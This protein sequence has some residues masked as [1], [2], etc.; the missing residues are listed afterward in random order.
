MIGLVG[1]LVSSLGFGTANIVI[2]K[3]LSKLTI[4]Q[5][6]MMSTLSSAVFLIP[7]VLI[8]KASDDLTQNAILTGILLAIME[9]SLYLVLYKAF[10]IANVSVATSMISTYPIFSAIVAILFL[11]EK[12][13]LIKIGLIVLIVVGAILTS[14]KWG[15]VF[16]D[17]FDRNDL[18]RGL[19]WILLTIIIHAIYFPFLGQFTSSGSWEIRLL[20]IKMFASILI[21]SL[22]FL[23]Q[24]KK[25]TPPKNKI[26]FTSLLGLLE[27]IGW[28]GF[29]WTNSVNTGKTAI[30]IALQSSAALVTAVLAYIFLKER[31]S[32]L[33]YFGILLIIV[34]VTGLSL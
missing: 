20:I 2:K 31:L 14:I 18:V 28:I 15:N 10:E 22:F 17:G 24:K 9:I 7:V 25:I 11:S 27:V 23:I 26:A 29:T 4:P 21:F 33:Q 5:T 12:L 13:N 6:L 30:I 34:C 8:N 19:P 32:K 1:A 3:S 16:K